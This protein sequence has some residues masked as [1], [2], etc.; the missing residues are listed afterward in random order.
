[1]H[2]FKKT[3]TRENETA[4]WTLTVTLASE[5]NPTWKYIVTVHTVHEP[6][7]GS[8]ISTQSDPYGFYEHQQQEAINCADQM[9]ANAEGNG[10]RITSPSR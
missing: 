9:V 10:Y 4:K 8:E 5:E 7:D 1:M 2:L 6:K 3:L